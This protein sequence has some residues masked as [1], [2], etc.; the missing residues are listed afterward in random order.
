MI[1]LFVISLAVVAG[2]TCPALKPSGPVEATKDGDIIQNLDITTTDTTFGITCK[3]FSDVV[4]KN[5]RVTHYPQGDDASASSRRSVSTRRNSAG[6]VPPPPPGSSSAAASSGIVFQNCDRITIENVRVQLVNFPTGPFTS[7]NNFNIKGTDSESPKLSNLI[8]SGGSSGV[9]LGSCPDASVTNWA[10]YNMHGPFPRGQ[11]VQ[12]SRV[13]NGVVSDFICKNQYDYSWPEDMISMWRSPNSTVENGL[14]KCNNANTGTGLM[15]EQSSTGT[16]D[17]D[18]DLANSWGLAK[19]LQGYGIG[20]CC[21]STYGGTSITFENVQCKDNHCEGKGGRPSASGLMF[22]A[23]HENP[24]NYADCCYSSDISIKDSK[25]YNSC[26][27]GTTTSD[28]PGKVV[29]QSGLNPDAFIEKG[30]TQSDFT[31]DENPISLELCFTIDGSKYVASTVTGKN[32][33]LYGD[34]SCDYE[35]GSTTLLL[36][37]EPPKLP[38]QSEQ[39]TGG[40]DSPWSASL[41]MLGVIGIIAAVV[42][43][44][45]FRRSNTAGYS[46]IAFSDSV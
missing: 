36:A 30:L 10:G 46:T 35:A 29:W 28:A 25:W 21:F 16:A 41:A 44:V 34:G 14:F 2:T 23:G 4:I 11:C 22:F 8:V 33:G 32:T 39:Q 6:G 31:L 26:R 40:A 24:S 19:N 9:W 12:F 3:G 18:V 20:G 42:G 45:A 13:T 43:G 7:Y 17:K 37:V 38:S 27:A 1:S 15:F 5:V